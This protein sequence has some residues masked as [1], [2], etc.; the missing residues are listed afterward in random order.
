[1]SALP[2]RASYVGQDSYLLKSMR[3]MNF[4]RD[5]YTEA[6]SHERASMDLRELEVWLQRARVYTFESAVNSL[7]LRNRDRYV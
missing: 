1:M 2:R 7:K 6:E 5:Q 4:G 3:G